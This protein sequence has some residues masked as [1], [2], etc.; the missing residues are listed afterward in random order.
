MGLL[1]Q[2]HVENKSTG[3][4]KLEGV[5]LFLDHLRRDQT[6][7]LYV[8]FSSIN[9]EF[10][11]DIMIPLHIEEK[12]E[13]F[14]KYTESILREGLEDGSLECRGDPALLSTTVIALSLT[15]I[16]A[17]SSH[18]TSRG[19]SPGIPFT[20]DDLF[21]CFVRIIRE[22]FYSTALSANFTS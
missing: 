18:Y 5:M 20:S 9:H 7:K 12:R 16:S 13:E 22:S 19:Y 14:S 2:E 11:K 4:D 10:I 17:L 21:G 1:F 8:H 6:F 15:F 3:A